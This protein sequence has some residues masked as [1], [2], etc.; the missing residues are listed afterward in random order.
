MK[1]APRHRDGLTLLKSQSP[2]SRA[3][4]RRDDTAGQRPIFQLNARCGVWTLT[5]I[6]SAGAPKAVAI[7]SAGGR[8]LEA[9]SGSHIRGY[10]DPSAPA[11]HALL[12]AR[13]PRRIPVR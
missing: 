6:G 3:E 5:G 2:P 1:Q 12:P 10:I 7:D 13:W 8:V 11:Q 9:T 4:R